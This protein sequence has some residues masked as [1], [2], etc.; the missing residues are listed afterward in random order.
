MIKIKGVEIPDEDLID[1]YNKGF[2]SLKIAKKYNCSKRTVLIK[3]HKI[4]IDL[5]DPGC[6]KVRPFKKELEK[7]YLGEKLPTRKVAEICQ[8]SRSTVHRKLKQYKIPRRDLAES[9]IKYPRKEFSGD[10]KEKAY[11]IG[12]SLG[13]LRVRKMWKNS[14]TIS[15]GCGSSQLPQ[16]QLIESLFS[17]YGRV[18]CK[19]NNNYYNIEAYVDL[20]FSFLSE[21]K[22]NLTWIGNNPEYFLHFL[23]GFIDAEG[24][25][26][27]CNNRTVM[28]IGNYD[29][30]ILLFIKKNLAKYFLVDSKLYIDRK[31]WTNSSGYKRND[32]YKMLRVHKK[33]DLMKL[34]TFLARTL[35]HKK[36]LNDL[37]FA[38]EHM[39]SR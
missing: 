24:S 27:I 2:S 6:S 26:Y 39:N 33:R 9:E 16:I 1:L 5:R 29:D 12:F 15:I 14:K 11:L 18:W 34:L 37:K 28:S 17:P 38:V 3:L 7:L 10:L 8:C 25:I 13:D 23:S 32:Y 4:G 22:K 35:R 21:G 19:N 20:S 30:E 31:L 36:R